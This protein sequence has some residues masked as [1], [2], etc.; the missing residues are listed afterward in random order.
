[1]NE[2]I[3][4]RKEQHKKCLWNLLPSK[5]ETRTPTKW[6]NPTRG[7]QNYKKRTRL[8][9]LKT[10]KHSKH[11]KGEKICRSIR[12]WTNIGR[13]GKKTNKRNGELGKKRPHEVWT[14]KASQHANPWGKKN[15]QKRWNKNIPKLP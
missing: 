15:K 11:Y 2:P 10:G 1:M 9:L 13:R 4:V 3:I 12:S 7:T 8:H 6:N 5:L 14:D